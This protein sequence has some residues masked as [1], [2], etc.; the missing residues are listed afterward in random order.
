MP[1]QDS[2]Q[3]DIT[4]R[5]D[6]VEHD[7]QILQR[8]VEGDKNLRTKGLLTDVREVR[9]DIEKLFAERAILRDYETDRA[10]WYDFMAHWDRREVWLKGAIAGLSINGFLGIALLILQLFGIH[11]GGTH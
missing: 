4:R 5:L 1:H 8:Q 10:V 6:R 2:I 11:V 9:K 7:V 3:D